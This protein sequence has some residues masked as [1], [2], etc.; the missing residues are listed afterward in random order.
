MF[1]VGEKVTGSVTAIKEYGFFVKLNDE[2]SGLVHISQISDDFV[3]DINDYVEVGQ[4]VEVTI[5]EIK[6]NRYSLTLK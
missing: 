5:M 4:E 2:V 1:N 3:N 6:D